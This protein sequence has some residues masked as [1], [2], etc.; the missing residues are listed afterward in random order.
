MVEVKVAIVKLLQ[1]FTIQADETTRY[2]I[3]TDNSYFLCFL[4]SS[5]FFGL[6]AAF[7]AHLQMRASLKGK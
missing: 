5:W 6:N 2:V 4:F 7:N 1:A 3:I